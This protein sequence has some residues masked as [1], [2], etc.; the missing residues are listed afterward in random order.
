MLGDS[1]KSYAEIPENKDVMVGVPIISRVGV[2]RI[3]T[4]SE[5]FRLGGVPAEK[6]RSNSGP[7][8]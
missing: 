4:N 5:K 6:A 1:E 3:R 7:P 2:P 8:D